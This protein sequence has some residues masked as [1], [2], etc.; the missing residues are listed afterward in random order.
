MTKSTRLTVILVAIVGD[1]HSANVHRSTEIHRPPR[2]WGILR[3]WRCL[4]VVVDGEW[5]NTVHVGT[6]LNCRSEQGHVHCVTE[7]A[8]FNNQ[9]DNNTPLPSDHQGL[10][11]SS[12][13]PPLSGKGLRLL[14]GT[15][16][17]TEEGHLEDKIQWPW[18]RSVLAL[19]LSLRRLLQPNIFPDPCS[20]ALPYFVRSL[21]RRH[22]R[23]DRWFDRLQ[24]IDC[25][26]LFCKSV[27]KDFCRRLHASNL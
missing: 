16:W 15:Y 23:T 14:M 19:V 8:V 3:A 13:F 21:R 26:E 24:L 18:T 12:P 1:A 7:S 10:S 27:F 6:D 17:T 20:T 22:L 11:S 5:C 25:H 4:Q 2:L 9:D